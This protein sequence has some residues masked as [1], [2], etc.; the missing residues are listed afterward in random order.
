M[1]VSDEVLAQAAALFAFDASLARPLERGGVPDGAVYEVPQDGTVTIV[2]FVPTRQERLPE[3]H[4]K[5]AFMRHLQ[6]G[7][8]RVP[9]FVPS[10]QGNHLE[11]I[12][13]DDTCYAVTRAL[14]MPGH[15]VDPRNPS[16]WNESFFRRWGEAVGR[17]HALTRGYDGGAHIPSWRDEHASF[18]RMSQDEA[19]R[20][21]WEALGATL[22]ALPED[23]AAF[24][25][26]HNDPHAFNFLVD[27]D[28]LTV[29]DFDV[30]TRS[31]F[32]LDIAIALLHPLWEQRR[33][34]RAELEDFGRR[35]V[36]SFL[37]GY[38]GAYTLPAEWL[39]RLMLFVR[40][41]QML[42]FTI[43]G[44][45]PPNPWRDA[46]RRDLRRHILRDEPL[47]GLILP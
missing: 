40:Y 6:G 21:R 34:P 11:V 39:A 38:A 43:L 12:A 45:E 10:T 24:G 8:L 15:H 3:A 4:D 18:A 9:V 33:R 22:A 26:I 2:K 31:W 32:A 42:F 17:L 16:E 20:T 1:H 37:A 5:L 28:D 30:A 35:F 13:V 36:A 41:R 23:P 47:T 25:V 44:T 7:G 29:L 19:V 14:K 46:T 27:G